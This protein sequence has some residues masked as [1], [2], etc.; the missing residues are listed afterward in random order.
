MSKNTNH[1]EEYKEKGNKKQNI[2]YTMPKSQHYEPSQKKDNVEK[3]EYITSQIITYMGN[4]RKLLP[5]IESTLADIHIELDNPILTVG[6]GFSGSGVVSRLFKTIATELYTNDLAGYSKTLNTCYLANPTAKTKLKI[7][8]YIDNAN[9]LADEAT[10][11]Q[12]QSANAWVAKHWSPVGAIIKEGERAY[13]TDINGRRIDA[14]RDYIETLSKT[15]QPY[16]LA[17][18]L[19]ECSIHNNTNGQFSAYFKDG[20]TGSYGGKTKTDVKRITKEIRIPYPLFEKSKCKTH[21]SQ[22]DTNEWAKET[23]VDIMYYDPPY[24][25]HPYNI[26]YFLLDIINDWDK[27]QDI[28]A[29]N[30]GQPDTRIKSMYNSVTHAKKAMTD[31]ITNTRAKYIMLSYNDGGIIPIV[32]LDKLLEEIST[33][34][35]TKKPIDHKTYNRLKGISNYKRTTEYKPVKEYLYVIKTK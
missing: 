20:T 17:P 33:G 22:K 13:F 14:M 4:K 24:N 28:P 15:Y 7:K 3:K 27:T 34:T 35:V 23:E 30:R 6:D 16:V 31:L 8:E 12:G 29:T 21:I 1:V 9:A 18:L 11:D 10:K 2:I 32:E 19:V 26:Y 25:K 5:I